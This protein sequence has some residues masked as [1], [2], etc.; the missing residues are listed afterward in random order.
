MSRW[1]VLLAVLL[2][3]AILMTIPGSA[4]RAIITEVSAATMDNSPV[5]LSVTADKTE[6]APGETI[7]L[8]VTLEI[9]ESIDRPSKLI[10][11]INGKPQK[12]IAISPLDAGVILT[13][14]FDFT[15]DSPGYYTIQ[16]MLVK[17]VGVE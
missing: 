10:M 9:N 12:E 8:T 17:Q 6:V 1:K 3:L 11:Y 4:E 7:H 13:Y 2:S 5:S 15:P 16:V 14:E